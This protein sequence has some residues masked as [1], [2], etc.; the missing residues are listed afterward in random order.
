[1]SSLGKANDDC[2]IEGNGEGGAI[3]FNH[4]F[5]LDALR[6]APADEIYFELTNSVNPCVITPTDDSDAFTYLVLPVRLK[7]YE[8]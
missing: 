8:S 2:A 3:G 6:A 4:R 1:V 7:S 5:L